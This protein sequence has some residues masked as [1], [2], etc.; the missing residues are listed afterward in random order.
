VKKTFITI[1][2]IVAGIVSIIIP[3]QV[4]LLLGDNLIIIHNYD[5]LK[6]VA[7]IICAIGFYISGLI[8]RKTPIKFIP[9]LF[10]S[11]LLFYPMRCFYFPL[12]AFLILFATISLFITRNEFHKKYKILSLLLM[13]GLFIY[14]LFSQPLIIREG[15]N[16]N[17]DFDGNLINGKVIWNFSRE[18][19]HQL[20]N[21]IFLD[22]DNNEVKLQAFKNKTVYVSFWATWCK[23]C[24]AEKPE[25]EKLKSHFKDNSDIIF[26]D[27]ILDD[28]KQNWQNYIDYN[29]P[30]G[31]QLRAKNPAK[32]RELFKIS[33]IPAHFIISPKGKF[34]ALR[35]IPV[36]YDLLSDAIK[37]DEF[38]ESRPEDISKFKTVEYAKSEYGENEYYTT[39]GKNRLLEAQINNIIDTL[40]KR[41]NSNF[42]YLVIK[43]TKQDNDSIIHEVSIRVS[44]VKIKLV[45]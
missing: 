36:A 16:I 29:K 31:L 7:L 12:I 37:L 32:T 24:L 30:Q 15:R 25:L 41:E 45:E 19:N 28:S 6:W 8:N 11:L 33:G 1:L 40:R 20:P 5:R 13:V 21:D 3:F 10:L 9:F 27:I 43:G 39:D 17:Q 35:P 38:I 2:K 18:K 42:V 22:T 23:P 14:F 26:I 34:K 4:F 44:D